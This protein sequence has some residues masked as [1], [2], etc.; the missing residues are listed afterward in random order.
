MKSPVVAA[1]LFMSIALIVSSA[2][3]ASAIKS[4]GHS[5]DSAAASLGREA[6]QNLPSNLSVRLDVPNQIKTNNENFNK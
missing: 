3:L 2:L 4:F 6:S 1:S 5:L